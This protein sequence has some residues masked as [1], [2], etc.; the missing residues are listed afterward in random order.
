MTDDTARA[1]L[2]ESFVVP[3]GL[4]PAAPGSIEAW[5]LEYVLTC[6]LEHKLAPPPPPK[7]FEPEPVRRII[8][9]PGRPQVLRPARRGLGKMPGD[10]STPSA[11]AKLLHAFFHHELQAAELMMWALLAYADAETP[12]RAGLVRICLDEIRHMNA[13]RAQ[14]ERLGHRLGD[15]PVR[16]W[17]WDRVPSCASKL[18][19]VSLMGMGLEG[20]NLEHAPHFGERL[21]ASGDPESA[22]VQELI[23]REELGHVRFAVFWFETWTKG[24]SFAV[25]CESLPPPLSPMLMRGKIFDREARLRAGMQEQFVTALENWSV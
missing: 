25:W 6:S 12:F 14:I 24:Q 17:F 10:L 16:D 9:A 5:A 1:A 8:A 2:A 11:R 13:Y 23:A 22:A 3:Q 15:F 19:F 18:A 20:A 21:L 4:A 7:L